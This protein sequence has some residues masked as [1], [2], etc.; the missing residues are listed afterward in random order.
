[1]P[2]MSRTGSKATTSSHRIVILSSACAKDNLGSSDI[3]PFRFLLR[4]LVIVKRCSIL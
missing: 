1:M 2:T 3:G 4:S